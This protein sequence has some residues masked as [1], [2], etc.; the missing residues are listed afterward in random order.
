MLRYIMLF[1]HAEF[2]FGRMFWNN[3]YQSNA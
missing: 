3:Y 1:V 2:C